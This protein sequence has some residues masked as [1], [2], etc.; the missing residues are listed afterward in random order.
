MAFTFNLK[1]IFGARTQA[2]A[3][4]SGTVAYELACA[5]LMLVERLL[6]DRGD[7]VAPLARE[8]KAYLYTARLSPDEPGVR[9]AIVDL[10][11]V[12]GKIREMVK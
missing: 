5:S 10:D 4:P 7:A 2:P 3:Q 11:Y 1:K 9:A 12:V 6:A 8:L